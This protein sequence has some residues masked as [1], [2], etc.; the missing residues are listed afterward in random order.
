MLIAP[1]TRWPVFFCCEAGVD[2]AGGGPQPG[3]GGLY[4]PQPALPPHKEKAA[5]ARPYQAPQ[6]L[7]FQIRRKGAWK[8]PG[9]QL[10]TSVIPPGSSEPWREGRG[11]DAAG[12]VGSRRG[13]LGCE[14]L[15]R[16]L[17]LL[18]CRG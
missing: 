15:A 18:P 10:E 17:R 13:G 11:G 9:R 7:L 12:A 2:S 3:P 5:P 14:P 4:R 16:R 1:R 6:L 8:S